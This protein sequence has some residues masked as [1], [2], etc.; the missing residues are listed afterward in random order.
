MLLGGQ[1]FIGALWMMRRKMLRQDADAELPLPYRMAYGV[2]LSPNAPWSAC[3]SAAGQHQASQ[4]DTMETLTVDICQILISIQYDMKQK[5]GR[6]FFTDAELLTALANAGVARGSTDV[7]SKSK[8]K[9]VTADEA[10]EYDTKQVS[11]LPYR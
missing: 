10:Q 5:K 4:H 11:V 2:V 7:L 1:N 9:P 6:A 3:F 8:E